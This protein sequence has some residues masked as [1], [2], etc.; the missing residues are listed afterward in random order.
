MKKQLISVLS[1]LL[2]SSA[3]VGDEAGT[4]VFAKGDVTAERTPPLA[5]AKGDSVE[6]DDTIATGEASRAQLLMIDGA[7]IAIRPASRLRIEEYTHTLPAAATV[8]T[9]EDKSSLSLLKG[10]FRTITGAIGKDDPDEY[11]VRTPVGV[12]GIRGTDYAAVFCNGDCTWVPGLAAGAPIADGLYLGVTAGVIVFRT[13]TTTIELRAGEYAFIPL[14][15]PEPRRLSDPPP[16]L[17]DD[18][19]LRFDASDSSAGDRG[20]DTKL[21]TRRAPE[22]SAPESGDGR[23]GGAVSE[24]PAAPDQPIIGVDPSGNPVDLTPGQTPDPSRQ[25]SSIAYGSSSFGALTVPLTD[26]DDNEPSQLMLD[27][28]GDAIGFASSFAGRT[29]G[30]TALFDIGTATNVD[31]GSDSMTV[32]RWGRWTG[33]SAS[34]TTVSDGITTP[35]DLGSQS[36]HWVSG[37]DGGI[38]VMPITGV[39]TYTLVGNTSPTDNLGNVGILGSATFQADFVNMLVDSTLV[40]DIAGSTWNASGQGN[41]GGGLAAHLFEGLYSTV[42]VDGIGGGTGSFSGFFSD[43]GPTADPNWPGG[44]GLTYSLQ[45]AAGSSTV[46]GAAVFGNPR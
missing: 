44:V 18:N 46:S 19:D 13:T 33:G 1:V 42:S 26:A 3:A 38:P 14:L 37:A 8:S 16:V 29:G 34:I 7:K 4:V 11:E 40:I 39:A 22:S 17:L 12:L 28:N 43:P 36:L 41:I 20:F 35:V 9:S 23:E 45:D 25:T 32:M 5:L 10:G 24:D 6:D 27:G 30:D 15:T 31:T 2:V 21:G